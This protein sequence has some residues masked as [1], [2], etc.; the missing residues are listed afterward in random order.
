MEWIKSESYS[1]NATDYPPAPIPG[2]DDYAGYSVTI[3][4]E[5]LHNPDDG[6]QRIA[7]TIK[8]SDKELITLEGYKVDR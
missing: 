2:G 6:I 3:A 8:R 5:P 4:A 1:A 7:V